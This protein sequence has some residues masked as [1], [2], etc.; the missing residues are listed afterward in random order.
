MGAGAPG[1]ALTTGD[2]AATY[3]S[4]PN[5]GF[6]PLP[7]TGYYTGAVASA[8]TNAL[9]DMTAAGTF[10]NQ[11][12]GALKLDGT[13]AN[14]TAT[15]SGVLNIASGA[16]M[17]V[18]A[19]TNVRMTVTG[20]SLNLAVETILFQNNRAANEWTE[21]D[22]VLTG[23][24]SLVVSGQSRVYF[25]M[26]ANVNTFSG[27]LV[28]NS[29]NQAIFQNGGNSGSGTITLTGGSYSP[30]NGNTGTVANAVILNGFISINGNVGS[31]ASNS[32]FTGPVTLNNNAVI[33]ATNT[34]IF[35][36]V[37]SG[38]GSL[39][40]ASNANGN[41][42]VLNNANTYT[43]GTFLTGGI[44]QVNNNNSLG[45]ASNPL[46]LAGGTLNCNTAVNLP[47]A[48]TVPAFASVTLAAA[49]GQGMNLTF[50]G[51]VTLPGQATLAVTNT[52]FTSFTN[53]ITGPG[54]LILTTAAGIVQ[55]L[56][57]NNYSGGTTMSAG[58]VIVNSANSF[59]SGAV[60]LSGGTIVANTPVAFTNNLNLSGTSLFNGA[61]S[62]SFSG[63]TTMLGSST[64][65]INDWAGVTLGTVTEAG[66][67]LSMTVNGLGTLTLTNAS[68][69]T[70][71]V[72]ENLGTASQLGTL[73]LANA[74]ALGSGT[75]VFNTGV[76]LASGALTLNNTINIATLATTPTVFAGS[77]LTLNGS[78]NMSALGAA[79]ISVNNT[80][81]VNGIVTGA[82]TFALIG[83]PLVA[84]NATGGTT[85]YLATGNLI[86]TA[87]NTYTLG[88]SVAG[89]TLT[90]AGNGTI[91]TSTVAIT[92]TD[93]ATLVLD[94]TTTNVATRV[95][96]ALAITLSGGSLQFIVNS[97]TPLVESVGVVTLGAGTSTIGVTNV[98]RLRSN[99]DLRRLDARG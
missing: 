59:G 10:T 88:T 17:S 92:V 50:S 60:T 46:T 5:T 98:G 43:G 66:G 56:G 61:N 77:T 48:V 67:A 63:V 33:D 37:V 7:A 2:F 30:T 12:I 83:T 20:G 54:A 27:G 91:L 39:T 45:A 95:P 68:S 35:N 51:T 53:T 32:I 31:T 16:L 84:A 15:V 44:L 69:F 14:F 26:A 9:V 62:I 71:G 49:I 22:P 64:L 13:A 96:A 6:V 78:L 79:N 94:N 23:P 58:T 29:A 11:T 81:T 99:P 1:S 40:V 80:T 90:L 75:Y 52:G 57:T 55:L 38:T 36:G 87:A 70:G 65:T 19:A 89:G 41:S 25:N 47:N 85:T 74:G 82:H 86:L 34:A 73:A 3:V 18:G 42:V 8:P 21:I 76:L 24:G 28:I 93:G 97:A 4:G 72:I